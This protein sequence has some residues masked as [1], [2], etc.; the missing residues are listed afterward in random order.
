MD[1]A[2]HAGA[3]GAKPLG[4]SGGGC[5]LAIARDGREEQLARALAPLGERLGFAV[6]HSGF[7]VVAVLE[8][9]NEGSSD[10]V[11]T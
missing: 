8:N 6:D 10:E 7:E 4:A 11:S 3:L 1:A 9:T 5:V 2:R